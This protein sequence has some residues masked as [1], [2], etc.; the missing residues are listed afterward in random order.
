SR[1]RCESGQLMFS[2]M[3]HEGAAAFAASAY[4]KVSGKPAACLSIAGPGATNLLTGLWD[5]KMDRAPLLALTGQVDLQFLGPGAFQEIDLAA[6][7]H[8]VAFWS[9][10]VTEASNHVELMNLAL[11]NAIVHRNVSH[12]IF[13]SEVQDAPA[14]AHAQPGCMTGRVSAL[15]VRPPQDS[16]NKACELIRAAQRPVIIAGYG[17][18]GAADSVLRFAE[19]LR[20]PIITTFKIKGL[21]PETHPLCCGVLGRAGTPVAGSF[22][23]Q[24]DVLI[25]L[26]SSFSRHTGILHDRPIIQ[27]DAERMALGKSHCVAVPVW[28][29]VGVTVDEWMQVLTGEPPKEDPRR[30]IAERRQ[31][32]RAE[33]KKREQVD[34]GRGIN[35]ALVFA[36][37]RR[38]IPEAAIISLDV[39]NNTYSFGR[40]F[41]STTQT[42]VFSGYLGSIGYGYP[43]AIGS[44]AASPNRPIWTVTGDGG[45]AQYCAETTTAVK[46][47]MPIKHVLLNDF[48]LSKIS[49]EQREE[50]KPVWATSLVNPDFARFVESCGGLGIRV[51]RAEELDRAMAEVAGHHG[52]ALVEVL[53]DPELV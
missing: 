38:H 28:G 52:P 44:W 47:G 13:P 21:F 10:T 25:V 17:A 37:M 34:R 15:E 43:A 7:F 23:S 51:D 2:G 24:A 50:G 26:G 19:R 53:T 31:R 36:A 39:G 6:A 20:I 33:V 29:D 11:K 40:Y 27:V 42:V 3:R 12:L 30:E 32:W 49:S 46:Y 4:A 8:A 22:M 45:Y 1:R 9:Q 14:P 41:E 16:L 48:E 5:A 35:S 18:Q